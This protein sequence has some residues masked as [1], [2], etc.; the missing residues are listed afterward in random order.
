MISLE[1]DDKYKNLKTD[2][3]SL[4]GKLANANS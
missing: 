1:D 3:N 4:K 2:E